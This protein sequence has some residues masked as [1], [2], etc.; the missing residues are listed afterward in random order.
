MAMNRR[1]ASAIAKLMLVTMT[2]MANHGD[3]LDVERRPAKVSLMRSSF[4]LHQRD[5]AVSMHFHHTLHTE[6]LR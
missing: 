4:Q 1:M 5:H 3:F 6:L 2:I